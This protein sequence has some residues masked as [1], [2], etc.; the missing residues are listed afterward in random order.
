MH[1]RF[2][3]VGAR[4]AWV[5][6]LAS[7]GCVIGPEEVSSDPYLTTVSTSF[8]DT[9]GDGDPGDGDPGD[10]DG[11]GDSGDG[12]GD[13]DAGD[14]DGDGDGDSGDGDGDGD[15][16]LEPPA[17]ESSGG[18]G[19]GAAA[20]TPT[21][22]GNVSYYL[23]AP[24]SAGPY[25][26]MIVYSGTE[27][28]GTMTQNLLMVKD[29]LGLGNFVFAVLD[30]VTYN[31][32]GDAG[33]TVLDAVRDLYDIDNDR[34]YLLSE[35]AGTTAGLELGLDL[36]QS[37]F[38]AYWANDVNASASPTLNAAQLGFQP[39][40][41]AGP[42]GDWP[43]AEAIVAGMQAANYRTPPP[44]PYD[45]PGSNTHGDPNQFVAAIQWFPGKT[46]Q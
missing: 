1:Y 26:L 28:A 46:R 17:G 9:S 10:G 15:G 21:Q 34:T 4:F 27:G 25:P 18:S 30:G 16:G 14:G 11:D 42:G 38:A 12:D 37:Y 7:I 36:R 45:G 6:A 33:A 35:S 29:P 8:D 13:G 39:Y 43:D 2:A 24:G 22:A 44:A 5:F 20:G 23:I 31:G 40:G 41:N 3:S 19:G 32:N